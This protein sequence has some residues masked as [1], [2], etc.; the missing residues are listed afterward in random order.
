[1]K[2]NLRKKKRKKVSFIAVNL[3]LIIPLKKQL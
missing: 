2:T 3:D 1:M